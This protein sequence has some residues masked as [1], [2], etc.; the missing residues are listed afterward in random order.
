MDTKRIMVICL[1]LIT[2]FASATVVF[3]ADTAKVGG[4]DFNIP[5]GFSENVSLAQDG[6]EGTSDNNFNVTGSMKV[7]FKGEDILV[8]LV[9]EFD[10]ADEV[11]SVMDNASEM[12]TAQTYNGKEGWFSDEGQGAYSFVYSQDNKIISISTNDKN[13]FESVIPK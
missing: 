10:S 12:A 4:I 8:I 5:D 9:M 13:I 7:F 11:K 3:S 2:V 1:I 6:L